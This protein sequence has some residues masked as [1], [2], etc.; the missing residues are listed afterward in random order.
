MKLH[1]TKMHGAGNDFIMIDDRALSTPWEDYPRMAAIAA[2]RTGLGCEGI[3]LLQPSDHADFY[4]R[5]LNPDGTIKAKTMVGD[6]LHP[7][8]DGYEIWLEAMEP[9][10]KDICGAQ[11]P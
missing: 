1:F 4:M 11:K 3:I 6:L 10:L 8:R 2:R 5:F 7:Y 9:Y